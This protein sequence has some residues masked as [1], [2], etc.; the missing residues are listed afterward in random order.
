MPDSGA[1]WAS[2][3]GIP[4]WIGGLGFVLWLW[5]TKKIMLVSDHDTALAVERRRADEQVESAELRVSDLQNRI[6]H[7]V[8][9]RDAWREAH[10]AEVE[11]RVAAEKA[12]AKLLE[13]SDLSVRLLDALTESL[14]AKGRRVG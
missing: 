2:W 13:T 4:V 7:L 9:D 8:V 6:D 3:L 11:A 1:E 5:L 12:A 14:R 10:D